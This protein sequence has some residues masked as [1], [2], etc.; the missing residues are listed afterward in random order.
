MSFSLFLRKSG[1][2]W[3]R[4]GRFYR[5]HIFRVRLFSGCA[6]LEDLQAIG[7]RRQKVTVEADD[8]AAIQIELHGGLLPP[9]LVIRVE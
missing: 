6:A 5:K 4:R 8:E 2:L 7:V 1:F 3:F 9:G